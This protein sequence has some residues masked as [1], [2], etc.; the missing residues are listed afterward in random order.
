MF[1]VT[2]LLPQA[3]KLKYLKQC[4]GAILFM[5]KK[6][7]LVYSRLIILKPKWFSKGVKYSKTI[8]KILPHAVQNQLQL[9]SHQKDKAQLN[10]LVSEVEFPAKQN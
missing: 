4:L 2:T 9:H 5:F 3:G 6:Y 1:S 10:P 8:F 7:K